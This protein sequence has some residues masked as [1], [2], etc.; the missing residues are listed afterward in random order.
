VEGDVSFPYSLWG[1][2]ERGHLSKLLVV[3]RERKVVGNM[4]GYCVEGTKMELVRYREAILRPCSSL[5][6]TG[7]MVG[8][9][10]GG[11]GDK[12]NRI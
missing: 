11:Y 7:I 12:G 10:F 6:P 2:T 5:P 9:I 1:Q 4:K 3:Y 8:V